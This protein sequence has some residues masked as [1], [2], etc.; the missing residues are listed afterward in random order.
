LTVETYLDTGNRAMFTNAGTALIL[1]PDCSVRYGVQSWET[2][3][4]APL[5]TEGP[6]LRAAREVLLG[7]AEAQ[8]CVLTDEPGLRL[9]CAG[10]EIAPLG[11]APGRLVFALPA[12][13]RAVHL[14]SRS[15]VPCETGLHRSDRRRLGVA[16][17]RITLLADGVRNEI[18]IDHPSLSQGWHALERAA[19]VLWRWTDGEAALPLGCS[20]QPGTFLELGLTQHPARYWATP[21]LHRRLTA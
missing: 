19:S 2:N 20:A 5:V 3:A 11:I 16:V 18:P 10:R 15:A 6:R 21:L 4:C 12:G 1:H 17:S 13:V 8:G 7:F 14:R 9:V